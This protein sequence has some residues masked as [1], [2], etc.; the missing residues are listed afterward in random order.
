MQWIDKVQMV[1]TLV[2]SLLVDV[3]SDIFML[4]FGN[5]K[6][7]LRRNSVALRKNWTDSISLRPPVGDG[8]LPVCNHFCTLIRSRLLFAQ[9]EKYWDL[10]EGTT[11]SDTMRRTITTLLGLLQFHHVSCLRVL[12]FEKV[13]YLQE[14]PKDRH[15]HLSDN[16]DTK[17][18]DDFIIC[19]S[20]QQNQLGRAL[21]QFMNY[22]AILSMIFITIE[23]QFNKKSLQLGTMFIASRT[24][25]EISSWQ[26][27]PSLLRTPSGC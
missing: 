6:V 7:R 26:L 3:S 23:V 19:S 12:S 25:M 2:I 1:E 5:G 13:N 17:L 16:F 14:E 11:Q 9:L 15:F 27:A 18:P 22:I 10:H 21:L 8:I 20:Y 24:R 4:L